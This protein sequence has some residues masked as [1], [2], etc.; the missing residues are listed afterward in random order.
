MDYGIK[1]STNGQ[2]KYGK[3]M[4]GWVNGLKKY[5]YLWRDLSDKMI[6]NIFINYGQI[7]G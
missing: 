7:N 3:I 6:L 1:A 2:I 4:D 5:N